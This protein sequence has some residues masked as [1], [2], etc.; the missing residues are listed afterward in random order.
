M[1]G[2]GQCLEYCGEGGQWGANSQQ[3][4]DVVLTSMRHTDVASTSF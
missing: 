2:G 4:H 1:G 3:A